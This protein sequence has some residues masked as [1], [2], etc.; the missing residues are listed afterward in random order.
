MGYTLKAMQVALWCATQASGFEEALVAVI[1]AGGDT[2]TNGAI[3]GAVLGA[4]FGAEGDSGAAGA[5]RLVE[6]RR[7]REPLEVLADRCVA[8]SG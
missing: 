3:G 7:G 2:D 5:E 6:I 1:S 8:A 4:R